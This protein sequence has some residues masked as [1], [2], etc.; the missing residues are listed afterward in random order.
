MDLVNA[1]LWKPCLLEL[2]VDV[3]RKN[4]CA[5]RHP[6]APLPKQMKA[7]MRDCVAI[8]LKPVAVEAPR[9]LWVFLEALSGRHCFE[10]ESVMA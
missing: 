5:T 1:I 3:A 4:E 9:E 7:R 8:E 2:A 6:T 10:G